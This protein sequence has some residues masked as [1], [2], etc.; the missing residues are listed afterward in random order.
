MTF[1]LTG[2]SR[3]D[4]ER[5]HSLRTGQRQTRRLD[6]KA[7]QPAVEERLLYRHVSSGGPEVLIDGPTPLPQAWRS[8]RGSRE[9]HR[10]VELP[11]VG[12]TGT[13]TPV[14]QSTETIILFCLFSSTLPAE[15]GCHCLSLPAALQHHQPPSLKKT[16]TPPLSW[17][18][19]KEDFS[20]GPG[21]AQPGKAFSIILLWEQT[22]KC[23]CCTR[24]CNLLSGP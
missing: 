17:L 14:I 1:C 22:C 20:G 15:H 12:K 4:G 11:W 5:R 18:A 21:G 6:G 8:G 2:S 3:S 7:D 23:C 24:M 9:Q 19:Y 16:H 13:Q 10:G